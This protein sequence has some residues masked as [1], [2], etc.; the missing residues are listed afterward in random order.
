M[1]YYRQIRTGTQE[2]H[3]PMEYNM[4]NKSKFELGQRVKLSKEALQHAKSPSQLQ[5]WKKDRGEVTNIRYFDG[6]NFKGFLIRVSFSDEY[7]SKLSFFESHL[8]LSDD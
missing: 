7:L 6:N 2:I 1:I 3:G 5:V 8:K 4:N